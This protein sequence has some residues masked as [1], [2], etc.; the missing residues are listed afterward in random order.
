MIDLRSNYFN[1]ASRIHDTLESSRPASR[2]SIASPTSIFR[3]SSRAR[4]HT[5]PQPTN[6]HRTLAIGF[7]R[8]D[9]KYAIAWEC[10]DLLI[11]LGT[12]QATDPVATAAPSQNSSSQG[13]GVARSG[14]WRGK[15][16]ERAVTLAGDEGK[17]DLPTAVVNGPPPK[18][19]GNDKPPPNVSWR[20]ST[21]RH[22]LGHRQLYLLKE[23][24][25]NTDSGMTGAHLDI[26]PELC[27]LKEGLESNLTLPTDESAASGPLSP[28]KVKKSSKLGMIGIRDMLR[29]LKRKTTQAMQQPEANLPAQ[30]STTLN[31]TESGTNVNGRKYDN[32]PYNY[33]TVAAIPVAPSRRKSETSAALQMHMADPSF[34]SEAMMVSHK[35]SPRRPSLASLFRIGQKHRS[36]GTG[37]S[38]SD[39]KEHSRVRPGT[40]ESESANR[41]G[42]IS[43]RSSMDD[44]DWDRMDSMSDLEHQLQTASNGAAT[45]EGVNKVAG[46]LAKKKRLSQT[47]PP[48]PSSPNS[49][50]PISRSQASFATPDQSV[51]NFRSGRLSNVE[52]NDPQALAL[53]TPTANTRRPQSKGGRERGAKLD[54]PFSSVRTLAHQPSKSSMPSFDAPNVHALPDLKL[55]MTPENIK[56]LLENAKVV[57]TRLI[58]C[59]SEVRG[60]LLRVEG[61]AADIA[62]ASVSNVNIMV[63]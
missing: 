2:A 52:E 51:S 46:K 15:N 27:R 6:D 31:T 54:R 34:S 18:S 10:A 4:S 28:S 23:M 30:S 50:L 14:S 42:E 40:T 53:S 44:S 39:S 37:F 59:L 9:A 35:S 57:T 24:L 62:A 12:G 20:A 41:S 61:S 56:P 5:S 25:S 36:G 32:H 19:P 26:S 13:T 8:I 63:S 49:K 43:S 60:L 3:S 45:N 58:D 16:R 1:L 29:S 48:R 33:N 17:P 38:V 55:A 7:Q 11:E 47:T 21:G 22:D